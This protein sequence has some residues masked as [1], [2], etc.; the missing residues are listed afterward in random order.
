MRR[1]KRLEYQDEESP[2]YSD[3]EESEDGLQEPEA[4]LEEQEDFD[5]EINTGSN[6]SNTSGKGGL[7]GLEIPID[8]ARER[9]T[10]RIFG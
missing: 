8:K 7:G 10:Y 9:L 3:S 6:S 1:G 2:P 4:G 5:I